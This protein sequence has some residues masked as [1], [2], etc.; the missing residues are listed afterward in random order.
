MA[1]L[2]NCGKRYGQVAF[3]YN[4]LALQMLGVHPRQIGPVPIKIKVLVP[5]FDYVEDVALEKLQGVQRIKFEKLDEAQQA[6][7]DLLSESGV[8]K[9]IASDFIELPR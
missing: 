1:D 9:D 3:V 6:W 4:S 8:T 5:S 2:D 7:V